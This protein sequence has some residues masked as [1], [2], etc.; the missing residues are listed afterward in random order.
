[1]HSKVLF[2][3]IGLQTNIHLD[4]PSPIKLYICDIKN[5]TLSHGNFHWITYKYFNVSLLL[6]IWILIEFS[7]IT[8]QSTCS[9]AEAVVIQEG[10]STGL[11]DNIPLMDKAK[12]KIVP[13]FRNSTIWSPG[14]RGGRRDIQH[15]LVAGTNGAVWFGLVLDRWL[16]SHPTR[17][18]KSGRSAN[19]RREQNWGYQNK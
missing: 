16:V 1:M 2:N 17:T 18:R 11:A 6:N 10:V 9:L 7:T 14:T 12:G 13:S 15:H 5:L 3:F 19:V 8:F 4:L